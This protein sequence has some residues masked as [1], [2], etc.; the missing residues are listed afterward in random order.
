MK[1]SLKFENTYFLV[2]HRE[3]YRG[4]SIHREHQMQHGTEQDEDGHLE[5]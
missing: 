4:E 3:S 1:D 2:L 5:W